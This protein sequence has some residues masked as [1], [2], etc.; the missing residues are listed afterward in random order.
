[1]II[2]HCARSEDSFIS[3]DLAGRKQIWETSNWYKKMN[4]P[5]ED[6]GAH[7]T[8]EQVN[9]FKVPELKDILAYWDEVRAATLKQLDS[10]TPEQFDKK[11]KMPWA[12]FPAGA[13]FSLIFGH[14]SQHIG[15]CSY[16]RGLQ[17]GMDKWP[18][19]RLHQ[20]SLRVISGIIYCL[21]PGDALKF[22]TITHTDV[23]IHL[24][25]YIFS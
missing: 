15:E 9:S 22:F 23:I 4:M 12:E 1:L 10:M 17:R 24:E 8:V 25:Y 19:F 7:Y 5:L 18:Y 11:V 14:T 2:Y 21:M 3:R 20:Q 16:L 13:I 6:V